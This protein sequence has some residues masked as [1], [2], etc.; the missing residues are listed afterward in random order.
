MSIVD[1][2]K[3]L[4]EKNQHKECRQAARRAR[5]N[6]HVHRAAMMTVVLLMAAVL[7]GVLVVVARGL[8]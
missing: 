6:I 3:R 5:R 4:R 8:V 2:V 1:H 7:L